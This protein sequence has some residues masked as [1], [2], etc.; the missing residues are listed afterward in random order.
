M[1]CLY[2]V[3]WHNHDYSSNYGINMPH[4]P[5]RSCDCQSESGG[6]VN[7]QVKLDRWPS[8][9][10]HAVFVRHVVYAREGQ[11]GAIKKIK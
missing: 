11:N 9:E 4:E 2:A 7:K 5:P 8:T 3:V 1:C 10:F 6:V